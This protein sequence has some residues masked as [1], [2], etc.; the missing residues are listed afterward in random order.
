[1]TQKRNKVARIGIY[2]VVGIAYIWA[3]VFMARYHVSHPNLGENPTVIDR[4]LLEPV[5]RAAA[6]L[7]Q[8]N[9]SNESNGFTS[10]EFFFIAFFA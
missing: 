1:M 4:I 8:R 7:S 3:S 9:D 10:R 5:E 2:I 6:L